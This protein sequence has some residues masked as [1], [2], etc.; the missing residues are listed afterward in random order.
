MSL[1][2]YGFTKGSP[3]TVL[4]MQNFS[5]HQVF[6]IRIHKSTSLSIFPEFLSIDPEREVL[7]G[8]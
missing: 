3:I 4:F 6:T 1:M 2:V 7:V 8:H 5:L